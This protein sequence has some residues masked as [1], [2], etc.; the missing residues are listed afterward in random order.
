MAKHPAEVFGCSFR[1]ALD[2]PKK[3]RKKYWC[4]FADD[5]CNKQSRLIKYPMGVCSVQYGDSLVA[6]CPRRFLQDNTVF[7]DIADHYFHTRNDLVVFS[8]I[9]LA[10]TGTLTM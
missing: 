2:L 1:A 6:L 3:G 7:K 4:P 10:Q 5:K 9:G 8:E